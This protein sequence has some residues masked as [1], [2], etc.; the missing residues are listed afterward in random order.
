[1]TYLTRLLVT[2]N[3][4]ASLVGRLALG[5]VIFPHGAQKVLGWFGGG[6]FDASMQGFAS[7]GIPAIFGFLA[8]VAEFA[9]SIGLVLGCLTRV[10]AFGIMCNMV[11]AALTV[12]WP[13][14]FF[15]NWYGTQKG[16]GYEFHIIAAGLALVLVIR[17]GGMASV[18]RWLAGR[19]G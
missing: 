12:S 8:I 4:A 19:R 18:D 3:S 6:G 2:D 16:E 11:V 7:L 13:H 15:M 14:G 17:G 1:M 9:G 10:A 5:I